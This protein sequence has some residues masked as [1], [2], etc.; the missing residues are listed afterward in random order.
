MQVNGSSSIKNQAYTDRTRVVTGG[1]GYALGD[2][3]FD[4]IVLIDIDNSI[5]LAVEQ[6]FWPMAPVFRIHNEQEAIAL[7]NDAGFG[8]T[9]NFYARDMPGLARCR[10]TGMWYRG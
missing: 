5:K 9:S 1:K 4:P 10:A 6:T 7:L 8:L 3:F 2:K